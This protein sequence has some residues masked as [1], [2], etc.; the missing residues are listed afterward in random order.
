MLGFVP[1]GCVFPNTDFYLKVQVKTIGP[2]A[3]IALLWLYPGFCLTARLP[4]RQATQFASEYSLYLL[5]LLLP[6]IS[7]T[8][9]QVLVCSK[10]EDG[11]FLRAQLTLRCDNSLR[12]QRWLAYTAV[13]IFVYPV[14]VPVLLFCVMKH[15]SP[16]IKQLMKTV[17]QQDDPTRTTSSVAA[18]VAKTRSRAS[19]TGLSGELMHLVTKFEQLKPDCWWT[20]IFLLVLRLTQTSLMALVPNQRVQACLACLFAIVGIVVLRELSPY[21]RPSE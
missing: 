16:K 9:S 5:E 17:V 6:S 4:H 13:G 10:F 8:L 3:A 20:H 12:R 1:V 14:C 11:W 15:Y 19:F 7:T 2:V 21:R 18:V